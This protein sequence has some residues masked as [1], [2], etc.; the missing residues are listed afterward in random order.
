MAVIIIGWQR[1]TVEVM[2]WKLACAVLASQWPIFA[3][4]VSLA[5][6]SSHQGR[7]A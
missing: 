2:G 7:I 5:T 4:G 1:D 6:L 3:G